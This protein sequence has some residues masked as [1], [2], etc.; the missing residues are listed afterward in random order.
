MVEPQEILHDVFQLSRSTSLKLEYSTV[1]NTELPVQ[2][3]AFLKAR[4]GIGVAPGALSGAQVMHTG[5]IS[6]AG[7]GLRILFTKVEY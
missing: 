1:D 2:M 6:F 3:M 5:W 7:P 4:V